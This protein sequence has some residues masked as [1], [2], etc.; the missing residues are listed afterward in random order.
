M[1]SKSVIIFEIL[2]LA[3]DKIAF[4]R[5]YLALQIFVLKNHIGCYELLKVCYHL[6]A[7]L[8]K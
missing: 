1:E 6:D 2:K 8:K 5:A 7:L 4:L 3:L